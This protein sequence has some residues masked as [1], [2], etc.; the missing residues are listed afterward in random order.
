[1]GDQS[2]VLASTKSSDANRSLSVVVALIVIVAALLVGIQVRGTAAEIESRQSA[3]ER[4]AS[5]FSAVQ[6]QFQPPTP[7]ESAVLIAESSRLNAL[8]VADG[9]QLNVMGAI[10]RLAEEASLLNVRVSS[11]PASGSVHPAERRVGGVE[12]RPA[13]YEI[14]VEFEGSFARAVQFVSRLPSSVAMS[15]LTASRRP[16]PPAYQVFLSVYQL[17]AKPGD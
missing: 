1:M 10:N 6:S 4:A 15:R 17:D 5:S 9:E 11:V 14:A 7:R 2:L 16:G 8:G 3:W 12:V 13:S